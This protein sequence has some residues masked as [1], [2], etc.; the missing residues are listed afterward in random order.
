MYYSVVLYLNF[1]DIITI[2]LLIM[3]LSPAENVQP[4]LFRMFGVYC[5]IVRG[6]S[7]NNFLC[8]V[9][10]GMNDACYYIS[11]SLFLI[12]ESHFLLFFLRYGGVDFLQFS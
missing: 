6:I 11:N 8:L 1:M 7:Q 3:A 5:K 2:I 4:I 9:R 12:L 10:K